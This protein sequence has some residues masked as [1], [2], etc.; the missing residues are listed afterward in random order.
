V[1]YGP[2]HQES[3]SRTFRVPIEDLA[4]GPGPVDEDGH[5]GADTSSTAI[6]NGARG[7]QGRPDLCGQEPVLAQV[8]MADLVR[9]THA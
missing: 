2:E 9:G 3:W 5:V 4:H 7:H 6:S 8:R 1:R